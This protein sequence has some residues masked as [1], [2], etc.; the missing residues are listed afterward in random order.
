MSGKPKF[1]DSPEQAAVIQAPSYA[2]VVVVA[3]AGSGKT[4]TMT[5]RIINLIEQGVSPEKILGL[6]FT[7]KAASELLS[8]VSAAVAGSRSGRASMFLKPEISTYDAFFQTIVRQYGLLVGFDQNTQPLTEAGAMQLIHTVLDKH[9]DEV[10]AFDG[11]LK[12]FN[13]LAGN[14]YQL[15]N[16][17]SGAMI[18][19]DCTSFDEAVERVR[20]WDEAFVKQ[21][22]KA[23][24]N[25][26]I[27]ADKP[28]PK[29]SKRTKK[30]SDEDF[31]ARERRYR[32]EC[33]TLCV[34][35][36]NQL[37]DVARKRDLLLNLV[38]D[39][40][41]EKRANNMAEFSDFTIAAFQLVTRFPSIGATYRKR[42]THVLLDE[43]QDTSTTQAALLTTLFHVDS[44]RRSA[45]NAV[46][47]PF[48]SIYAWRGASPGAFR[49]LQHDFGMSE[50]DKPFALS[51]TRRNSRLVLEAANNLTKPLRI[52]ARRRS[53]SLMRE[54]DVPALS[55]IE[56]APE[57]TIGVL[58][59]TTRGQEID[60]VV[61]FS[62]HAIALHTPSAQQQTDGM[63]DNRPHVAV[64]F[65]AKSTMPEYENALRQA[66]LSVL[67]VGQS[68]LLER[69]EIQDI[70]ALLHVICDHTDSK[71]LMRLLAT[72]R[73]G[74]KA[75]DLRALADVAEREN[76]AQRYR[77]LVAAGIIAERSDE[78]DESEIRAI[79]RE[80]R[81]QVPNAVFLIDI[82]LREDLP[83]LIQ[84]RLSDD[85]IRS[86][87]NAAQTLR[88]TQAVYGRPLSETIRTAIR[89]L[90]LDIDL[91]LAERMR[92][93]KRH[94]NTALAKSSL[95]AMMKLVDSYLN[96]I[97]AQSTP[98]LRA[99]MSWVD[100]LREASEENAV[101][102]DTPVDVVLMTVHQSKGLE[103][104]AVAVVGMRKGAFPSNQGD[105]LTV[106]LDEDRL[107]G[108]SNGEW[109]PPE[110]FQTAKTWLDNPATV[111]V[112]VRVDAAILP[113]FPHDALIGGDPVEALESLD[114]AEVIDDEVYGTLRSMRIAEMEG[115]DASSLYLTQREEYGL[116]LHADERRLAYVALTRARHEA[117]LTY[118]TSN[119]MSRD[120]R[121]MTGKGK[122]KPSNFWSE[123]F[124]SMAGIAS[125]VREP[126]GLVEPD[127]DY[128]TLFSIGSPLPEGYFVGEHAR[129]FENAV[130]ADAWNAPL[131]DAETEDGLPWPCGLSGS[132][133]RTFDE[134]ASQVRSAVEK[135]IGASETSA[136][137][138]SE[139]SVDGLPVAESLLMRARLLVSDEHLMPDTGENSVDFDAA[140]RAK[141]ER[142]L[143]SGRQ[144]V[145]SL[146][147]R[148]GAMS[149]RAAKE[150]WRGLVR[151]IPHVS[152][153]SAQLGTRFHAWA[154]QFIMAEVDAA[155]GDIGPNAASR[156]GMIVDMV[157]EGERL[158][159]RERRER[160]ER[161]EREVD[162]SQERELLAWKQRL[163]RS[164]WAK[165]K[166]AWVERQLVVDVPQL[167]T[168]VNGKLDA[169]F[170]GGVNPEDS[171]KAYTIVDWKTGRKPRKQSEIDEKLA[172]LDMYR[173]LLSA[174]ED[175]PLDAIDGCLYY[176]S[177]AEEADRML[178]AANK[179][180]E[181][182]LAE[183]SY[184][185]PEQS[186]N[187]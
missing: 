123:V 28:A 109:I 24:E 78:M 158:A 127:G 12:G 79:V 120:P 113:R 143:A 56:A 133:E 149:E 176:L 138:T 131:E 20:T 165:R 59:Y 46:G 53:S 62:K 32:E 141:G 155:S 182:I 51:V 74:V 36:A 89:S 95:D 140:V 6:T 128:E 84:G 169:V 14:V 35:K 13:T 44:A 148:A 64:L 187:D 48:Q 61:R 11:D 105:N 102:P 30:E 85:G 167:G 142:I 144:S 17:I 159:D 92:N 152:S 42:Y 18:G 49:M 2:D 178:Q 103:W 137:K 38:A 29:L 98:S 184:G 1:T 97:A 111:P 5:R 147:A 114:D 106:D 129:D 153:P 116:R 86:V 80:Y 150:Y 31:E 107:N 23:L 101:A 52:P 172:Q 70:L 88:Q 58:G 4:Y 185:I 122:E 157:A 21:V 186:D 99:F 94:A 164:V 57:G 171:T 47:D 93:P 117:L 7:R 65:R 173:I 72:P 33:R 75:D 19:G 82:M 90:N 91:P 162:A 161:R 119:D 151:P 136:L 130:V 69:P 43:Y 77:A 180:E 125:A 34:Y 168:I 156:A 40:N 76:T 100:S 96:E 166:P 63:K 22:A 154:E 121:L 55:N 104:D 26:D 41:A 27:P 37:A 115:V 124:D 66:G 183:L 15:S 16:A 118:S 87:L 175:V 3:G 135:G 110:Y 25:D 145:T 9:M 174:M 8:R 68:A 160:Q 83:N 50:T 67:T 108:L 112:P 181:E 39:Y 132:M 170:F 60:A 54:V 146:Q 126:E 163:V 177:E 134:S 71:S 139:E 45:V 81:D 10:M 179:T 73:F